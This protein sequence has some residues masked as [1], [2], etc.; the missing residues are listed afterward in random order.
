MHESPSKHF[1][2]LLNQGLYF[3][4]DPS[5]ITKDLIEMGALWDVPAPT[6]V[7]SVS[8]ST[9]SYNVTNHYPT[10]AAWYLDQVS[11]VFYL[12]CH[13]CCYRC[14]P[15]YRSLDVLLPVLV[16]IL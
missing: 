2:F 8:T 11:L 9:I 13:C 6:N 15:S 3:G 4:E 12:V 10:Y 1:L 5:Q 16:L 14:S 7:T